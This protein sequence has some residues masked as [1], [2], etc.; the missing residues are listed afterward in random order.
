MRH[1]VILAL[2]LALAWPAAAADW[3]RVSVGGGASVEVP[4][5]LFDGERVR[6][7]PSIIYS[8]GLGEVRMEVFA[9][10]NEDRATMRTIAADLRE[11]FKDEREVTYQR[12]G[13]A[14]LV[15][16]GYL[17][18]TA[19]RG[20]RTIFYERTE[21]SPDRSRLATMRL[22]YPESRRGDVDRF[23]RRIGNSLRRPD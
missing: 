19:L 5:S 23:I 20:G 18:E 13:Q 9:W 1:L 8:D 22:V 12:I 2:L 11:A 7:G 16:S 15:Q 14:M 4:F 10:P 17:D 6:E 21:R 3:Q